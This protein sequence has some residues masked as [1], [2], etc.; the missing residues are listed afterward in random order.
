VL[1]G[2]P[3]GVVVLNKSDAHPTSGMLG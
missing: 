1:Q 2:S 3:I